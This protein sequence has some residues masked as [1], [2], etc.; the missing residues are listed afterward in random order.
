MHYLL[1]A[2][3]RTDAGGTQ[4]VS[5]NERLLD[6]LDPY[7]QAIAAISGKR[8]KTIEDHR[9]MARIEFAGGVYTD[10]VLD[11]PIN[12]HKAQLVI[13]GWNILRC[14]Q[15]EAKR[16]KRGADVLRG[17]SALRTNGV[18]TYDD[19]EANPINPMDMWKAGNYA[20]RK[21]VGIGRRKVMRTRPIFIDWHVELDIEIDPAIFDPYT[22]AYIWSQAGIYTG[23]GELRPIYGRF[24]GRLWRIGGDDERALVPVPGSPPE[25]LEEKP[26][27]KRQA[28]K[29]NDDA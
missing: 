9:E 26:K 10:P 17:I 24:G 13:P 11:W 3:G 14:L 18:F 23:L 27:R 4:F 5:H 6:P 22:I 7:T 20:L 1:E 29:S 2:D 25:D 16:T 8:R 15:E 21:G 12:G 19:G 28:K